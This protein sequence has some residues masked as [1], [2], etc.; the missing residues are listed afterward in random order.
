[1]WPRSWPP[2]APRSAATVTFANVANSG[3]I[4]RVDGGNWSGYS[5][6]QGIVIGSGGT[7]DPN[8][9]APGA[10]Y[11]IVAID[12]T[13]KIITLKG[14]QL[15]TPEANVAVK[16]AAL[17]PPVNI[18][19]G[20]LVL[21]AGQSQIGTSAAP[22]N[23]EILGSGHGFTAR[24]LND[25]F[26]NAIGDIPVDGIYSASAS[27][28]LAATGSI[29][30]AVASLFAKIQATSLELQVYGANSTI[31]QGTDLLHPLHV[32][33][34][35]QGTLQAIAHGSIAID[36]AQG[37]LYVLDV[38]STSGDVALGA[39]GFLFNGGNLVDPTKLDSGLA[40]DNGGANVRGNTILLHPDASSPSTLWSTTVGG[41]GATSTSFN[42]IS[43]YS[44]AG[45]LSAT[46]GDQNVYI[47]QTAGDVAL[48]SISPGADAVAFITA[49][50]GSIL[51]GRP[52]ENAIVKAG[53]ADLIASNSVGSGTL[54]N[55]L[56]GRIVSSVGNI[57]A[58]ATTGDIWLWNKGALTVGGVAG[59][60]V[61]VAASPY[62]MYA[63]DG[64]INIQTSS[65]IDVIL[66]NFSA[67][68]IVY[69]AGTAASADD[70]SRSIRVTLDSTGGAVELDAGNNVTV[71]AGAVIQAATDILIRGAYLQPTAT[72]LN[73]FLASATAQTQV[74]FGNVAD[75]GTITLANGT[76]AALGYAVGGGIYVQSAT[77]PNGN[78]AAFNPNA[79][80][81]IAAINGATLTLKS[82]QT[83]TAESN[84]TLHLA[85]VVAGSKVDLAGSFTAPTLTVQTGSGADDIELHP[86]VLAANTLIDTGA[87]D[88]LI[89]VHDMPNLT[90]YANY[91]TGAGQF[92]DTVSLDGQDGADTYVI[93]AT[94][95]SSYVINVN[96]SGALDS[97]LNTLIINGALTT[98]GQEFLVRDLFVAILESDG[99]PV[100]Q[101]INYNDTIT[102][103]LQINGGN[104]DVGPDN[105]NPNAYGDS[106]YLDGNSAVTTINA[107]DGDDFFQ[108]GQVYGLSA[109]GLATGQVGAGIG[110]GL[111]TTKTTVGNLSDGV[112]KSTVLYGGKGTD[113]F[114][115]YSNKADLALI[116]GSGDDTFIVRAFLVAPARISALPV[117]AATTR[118]NTTSMRRSISRAAPA[119]TR[120]SARHRA[121]D[122]FVITSTGIFGGGL[123]IVY[124]N[125]QAITIDGLEGN[126]TFY[127]LSTPYDVVTTI[128]G[129]DGGDT[130]NIGGDVTGAVISANTKGA[131]S[132]TDNSVS[133]LDPNYNNTFVAGVSIAVGGAD[134]A[135]I[136]QPTQAIVHVNDSNSLTY[137][138]VSTPTK[139]AAGA[140]A[141]V[142]V[143]PTLP[144][145]EWSSQGAASLLVSVDGGITWA[146]N[147][148][149]TFI[150][151]QATTQTVLLKAAPTLPGIPTPATRP[152]SS[153]ARSS[154]PTIRR[155]MRLPLPTVKVTRDRHRRPYHRP[156]TK[157]DV[158]GQGRPWSYDP[159]ADDR[160]RSN[161]LHLLPVV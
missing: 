77:D 125:I 52:D 53:M 66:S 82:G 127:V 7:V 74:S 76:W 48:M 159:Q 65:P 64:S 69:H 6:G 158:G 55:G 63:P 148:I 154:V 149:L 139:L 141:Y 28:H 132:V 103:G 27:V 117:A 124:S 56:T 123:D 79:Y 81:T 25:I 118:S 61:A 3:T 94:K 120:W 128:N 114:E 142:N 152:S 4:T 143:T 10:Y 107:G 15:L 119:S 59:A 21:E 113:T 155:S 30:D 22:I 106:Y 98:S 67:T 17:A 108:I 2:R 121:N 136:G 145:A 99:N 87:G 41:I 38:L 92:V 45:T 50:S 130:V 104:V 138:T 58:I 97:G 37:D 51:N 19:G 112:D 105:A 135:I 78:G 29:Y 134:G 20:S 137:M 9:N 23:I 11:T 151:G 60:V 14:G 150:G 46:A 95:D 54:R 101:R 8:A 88:D 70:N 13:D 146:A 36:Q 47:V 156:G 122:T 86:A 85:P 75:S 116:G 89:H 80:Y 34:V 26:I 144:S 93:D 161:H 111:T 133:S 16:V 68:D 91:V 49:L 84:V 35:G 115:V 153:P 110:D 131:S 90:S 160:R 32:D 12:A 40:A 83:L 18:E 62:A 102:G 109:V 42:I 96:D 100:Y 44:G 57:E 72:V 1:M 129:G 43:G 147:A 157:I 73:A 24:A 126:D 39:A 140:T 5:I 31:G 33:I 71:Q